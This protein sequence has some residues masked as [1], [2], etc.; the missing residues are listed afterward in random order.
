MD[1]QNDGLKPEN[2]LNSLTDKQR[3]VLDLLIEH[4]TSK[5]IARELG[6]SPHTVDQRLQFAREKLG[7]GSRSELA[8]AYRRLLE[9]YGQLTYKPSGIADPPRKTDGG[10]GAQGPLSQSVK[11]AAEA[12]FQVGPEL[13]EGRYGTL[14]RLGWM[15]GIAVLLVF[16][17]IGSLA[18]Y[19][20][21]AEFWH[22]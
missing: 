22:R 9:V 18:L 11:P 15:L 17:V 20:Q 5:E 19:T 21:I 6:I 4:K 1:V 14:A 16:V 8:Q 13:F 7:A 12:D 2:A 3:R 10:H